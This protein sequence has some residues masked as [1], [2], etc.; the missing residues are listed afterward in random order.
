ME[1]LGRLA[2]R[3]T[4]YALAERVYRDAARRGDSHAE[5]RLGVLYAE[6]RA[7]TNDRRDAERCLT[8]AATRGHA[9]SQFI[10]A[11]HYLEHAEA[12]EDDRQRNLRGQAKDLVNLAR[13]QG[14]APAE[15]LWA[16]IWGVP[17]AELRVAEMYEAGALLSN[18]FHDDS[19]RE[20]WLRR[21]ADSGSRDA[22]IAL[23]RLIAEGHSASNA[24]WVRVASESD[25]RLPTLDDNPQGQE[26]VELARARELYLSCMRAAAED[27]C[28]A[29]QFRIADRSDRVESER[30][31]QLAAA[32]DFEPAKA[33]LAARLGDSAA[34]YRLG[35]IYD[36]GRDVPKDEPRAMT[37]YRLAAEHGIPDAQCAV[38]LMYAQGRGTPRDDAEAV[39]WI[40][41]AADQGHPEAQHHSLLP[42]GASREH[43][44]AHDVSKPTRPT[45]I[46]SRRRTRYPHTARRRY[47]E[48]PKPQPAPQRQYLDG[49]LEPPSGRAL[50]KVN[51]LLYP[52]LALD[53]LLPE[54]RFSTEE[55][56]KSIP[57]D[58]R[59]FTEA[60][61]ARDAWG[62]GDIY[63]SLKETAGSQVANA[64][65]EKVEEHIHGLFR[66]SDSHPTVFWI[67]EQSPGEADSALGALA[68]KLKPI[69][70]PIDL[71]AE[72]FLGPG[73][74]DELRGPALSYEG[75]LDGGI[76]TDHLRRY[77]RSLVTVRGFGESPDADQTDG[78]GRIVYSMAKTG[79][80]NERSTTESLLILTTCVPCF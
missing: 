61:P 3:L 34:Q 40:A 20:R 6:G 38:G 39:K 23:G 35:K 12:C 65:C 1:I 33:G 76:L 49:S 64:L 28:A 4:W 26:E 69:F 56:V 51:P 46:G 74:F 53:L 9:E 32:Q 71:P 60:W 44:P 79:R 67:L 17:D 5:Y 13:Q 42:H 63:H 50:E 66:H 52:E 59:F 70:A 43:G 77:P 45:A 47:H 31:L 62:I 48:V 58:A 19:A 78:I 36:E 80:L 72:D 25:A 37:W 75:C 7:R 68:G 27:G 57:S 2:E 29:A 10:L 15:V 11:A 54:T 24:F 73:A 14:F 8:A 21:A 41:L 22:K 30:W 55:Y 16:A 18:I